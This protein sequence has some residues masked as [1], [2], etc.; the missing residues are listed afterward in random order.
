MYLKAVPRHSSVLSVRGSW[1]WYIASAVGI[2]LVRLLIL[3]A[4]FRPGRRRR[5]RLGS[6]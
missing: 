5:A 3:D 4:L 1:P 6:S 2:A